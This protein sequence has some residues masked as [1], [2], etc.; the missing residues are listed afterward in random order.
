M[1]LL[2]L[3]M[4]IGCTEDPIAP[5]VV[6][7]K[8]TEKYEDLVFSDKI[9]LFNYPKIG[10]SNTNFKFNVVVKD[11]S[12]KISKIK[13]DFSYDHEYDTAFVS[14]DTVRTK[15]KL[16]GYNTIMASVQLKD[17][18]VLSCSTNVWITDPKVI[19]SNVNY[20]FFEP[21]IYNGK[22]ISVT[23]G[24]GHQAQII[25]IN[26][27][28]M[29]CYF[30]GFTGELFR[31]MHCS[32]PSFDGKKILFDN[33]TNYH[34]SYYDFE[35]HDSTT[36]DVQII[37]DFYP[38]GQITW[39]LDSKSI[40]YVSRSNNNQWDG[41]KSYDLESNQI[42][43]LYSKGD[44]V[45]IIP[46][47]KEKIAILERVGESISKLIIYNVVSKSIEREYNDIPFVAPFR[48][49]KD[50]DRIYFDGE[51]A[52]YSISRQKTFYM[53]FDELDLSS[54]MYGEADINMEGN[55]FVLSTFQGTR[56]LYSI[57]LPNYF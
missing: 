3:A 57:T 30:C 12:L 2:F 44:F 41:I 14:I 51:L 27:Y 11:T 50:N 19:S 16:F 28:E 23:H 1:L 21:N 31:E 24:F 5:E 55:Q 18:S 43:S 22:M 29:D 4:L 37:T 10:S 46:D 56:A 39:S 35:K 7:P 54:H 48:M 13:Y 6:P 9:E 8:E 26:T 47:Q 33:G 53:Q 17:Q 36:T 52:F 20:V 42:T 40:F 32:I 49:L 38:I 34:F 25:D 15:F 45:C